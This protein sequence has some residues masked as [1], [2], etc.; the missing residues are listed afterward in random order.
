M[1]TSMEAGDQ[2]DQ[3]LELQQPGDNGTAKLVEPTPEERDP[4]NQAPGPPTQEEPKSMEPV[5]LTGGT[6]PQ[7]EVDEVKGLE[8]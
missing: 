4:S 7:V 1:G 8:V 2:G 3:T 5:V 6:G